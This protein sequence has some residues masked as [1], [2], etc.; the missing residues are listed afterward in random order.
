[1]EAE[2]RIFAF[3]ALC[4]LIREFAPCMNDY[5]YVYDLEQDRYYIA[6]QALSR[7]KLPGSLFDDALNT[8]RKVVYPE[9]IA[10]L[11]ED[12]QAL[13]EGKQLEHNMEYRWLGRDG[14]PIWIDCRGRLIHTSDGKRLLLGCINEIGNRSKADNISGL[15]GESAL[16]EHMAALA[17][18]PQAMFLRLGINEFKL[19]TERHGMEYGNYVLHTVGSCISRC[20]S[21][22]QTA[23]HLM[24][25]EF[26]IVDFSGADTAAMDSLYQRIRLSVAEAVTEQQYKAVYTVSAG[27]VRLETSGDTPAP[28]T[29]EI[30]K[31]SEFALAEAKIRDKNQLYIFLSEDYSRFLRARYIRSCLRKAL[32]DDFKGFD[33]FFQPIILSNG[34]KLFAAEALLRFRTQEGENIFPKEFIPILEESGLIIPVGRWIIRTALATCKK[35][36]RQYPEFMI[37]VNLSYIQLLNSPLFEDI[38]AALKDAGLPPS[39][40]IVELTESGRLED[41]ASVRNIWEKLKAIGVCIALD[42][43]GTG[44]SNLINIGDLRPS[45]VKID[46]SFTLKALC[47][48]YEYELLIHIIRMVHSIGLNLVVEGIETLDELQYITALNPD[49]IQG[50][51]YSRPCPENEFFQKYMAG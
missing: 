31:R 3:D 41:T 20:L 22:G 9:D 18:Q 13:M 47:N 11:T 42:D 29:E 8:H 33:L 43:F 38:T 16:R 50:Y 21:G 4:E 35:I 27:L 34:E 39:C 48:T 12:L 15:L 45:I 32:E 1:M 30:L 24:P 25:D 51:Y 10:I 44:Y 2:N 5:L 46:R 49:Y 28:D 40:L 37:S 23:Y 7:F 36:R 17:R 19:I 26:M 6:E 14:S